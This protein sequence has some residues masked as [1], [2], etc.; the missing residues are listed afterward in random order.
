MPSVRVNV[1]G[2]LNMS[3]FFKVLA[4]GP[5]RVQVGIFGAKTSRMS[6]D[7]ATRKVTKKSTQVSNTNAELG[8]V[9]EL[10]SLSRNIPPRSFLYM[11]IKTQAST[12]VKTMAADLVKLLPAGKAAMFL[13]RLGIAAENLVQEAFASRGFGRW[14]PDKPKTVKAKGSDA[15]LIDSGQLRRS[16]ASR[17]VK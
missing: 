11:P 7:K 14:A 3:Q 17:V 1:D 16:I 10:G 8:L 4:S 12:L 13:K 15:P 5:H 6:I 9:H 2:L